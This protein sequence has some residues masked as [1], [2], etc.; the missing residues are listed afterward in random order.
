MEERD[1]IEPEE[2]AAEDG[3]LLPDREATTVITPL[4]DRPL[5][6]DPTQLSPPPVS[7]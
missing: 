6:I 1:R 3:E 4:G 2:P 7:E 5:P